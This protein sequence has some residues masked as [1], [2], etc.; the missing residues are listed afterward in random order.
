MTERRA[1]CKINL[2]LRVVRRRADGFHD[3]ETV[4]LAVPGLFDTVSVKA[5]A[6]VDNSATAGGA[7]RPSMLETSGLEVDCPPEKNICM[8]ALR[9]L[10]REYGT[11]ANTESA[12]HRECAPA[13]KINAATSL[14]GCVGDG[15]MGE[16]GVGDGRMGEARVGLR[17]AVPSGAG[18]GG[19]S[20]DG[21]AVLLAANEEFALGMPA[22]ELE[23]LAARLGSDVPFFIRCAIARHGDANAGENA[24]AA[25]THAENAVEHARDDAGGSAVGAQ[26]CTGRGEVMTPVEVD[27]AGMWLVVVKPPVAVSTAEAYAGVTPCENGESVADTVRR[28]VGEWRKLLRNDFEESVFAHHPELGEIKHALYDAGALYASM[29]GSGSALFG[30][31]ERRP[32][33]SSLALPTLSSLGPDTSSPDADTPN[34]PLFIH[35]ERL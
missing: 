10:Q 4:M 1:Y 12:A 5:L 15:R 24:R 25:D 30:L 19:G 6:S 20:A 13:D 18:L 14:A 31:F 35:V 2:G 16:A 22:A 34:A 7:P 11:A 28:P 26:L 23:R 33:L 32:D 17:K 21:A 3:I 8:K 29:S 27:L 9:L